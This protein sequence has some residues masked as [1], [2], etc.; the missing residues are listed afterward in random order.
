MVIGAVFQDSEPASRS[1]YAQGIPA[2]SSLVFKCLSKHREL[3]KNPK[4]LL[5]TEDSPEE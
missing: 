5:D 1:P 2:G 3:F 4:L